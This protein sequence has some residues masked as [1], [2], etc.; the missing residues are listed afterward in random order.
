MTRR[1]E[2]VG[3]LGDILTS[4]EQITTIIDSATAIT[5]RHGDT[6]TGRPTTRLLVSPG[7]VIKQRTE[8]KI[9]EKDA[10]RFITQAIERE[11]KLGIYH[12]SKTWFL[13]FD[14]AQEFPLIANIT[15]RLTPLNDLDS[16]TP[17]VTAERYTQLLGEMFQLYLESAARH[18]LSLDISL[19]NFALDAQ[20]KLYYIDDDVYTWDRFTTFSHYLGVLLRTQERI[21]VETARQLGQQLHHAL[22]DN[23]GDKLWLNVVAEEARSLFLPEAR[24]EVMRALLKALT[25]DARGRM[26]TQLPASTVVALLADIHANAPA[27]EAVLTYLQQ[28][29][30][31]DILVMGDIVGYGPHPQ[32]CIDILC[33]LPGARVLQGNHDHAVATQRYSLG[34]SPVSRWVIEWSRERLSTEAISWLDALPLYL[35]GDD[36][37]AVHGAPNDKTFFNAYV[38]EMTYEDNLVNMASRN[39]HLCFHGHTHLQKVYYRKRSMDSSN[40]ATHQNM[41]DYERALVCP[42]SIGQPRSGRPGVEFALFDRQSGELEFMHLE[43]DLSITLRDMNS[44]NFPPN[45]IERL[46]RGR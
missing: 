9:K 33:A 5:A 41:N 1:I 30:I 15:A 36:W 7:H 18:D 46:G 8:Y 31:N 32:Q 20:Q 42:G 39:L 28:R 19:S 37:I 44:Y 27:L 13:I 22:L 14:E 34:F 10:R 6:F 21:D 16:L 3:Q 12:P 29:N 4:A 26:K 38:Y 11:R 25:E 17:A 45:L 23:F 35:Q 2:V 43:Y 24:K 40:N